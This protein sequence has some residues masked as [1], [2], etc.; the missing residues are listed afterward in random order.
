MSQVVTGHLFS[1]SFV[2]VEILFLFYS[3]P[4]GS[5]QFASSQLK[6]IIKER[7]SCHTIFATFTAYTKHLQKVRPLICH[8]GSHKLTRL[9][10]APLYM[11]PCP[12]LSIMHFEAANRYLLIIYI[13]MTLLIFKIIIISLSTMPL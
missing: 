11:S 8:D 4:D 7:E 5:L 2:A 13:S 10:I 12:S 9:G 6:S 3:E 1:F